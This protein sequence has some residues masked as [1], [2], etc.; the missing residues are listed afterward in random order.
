MVVMFELANCY[1]SCY[2]YGLLIRN[3]FMV[4]MF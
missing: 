3:L 1:P 2:G 4:V